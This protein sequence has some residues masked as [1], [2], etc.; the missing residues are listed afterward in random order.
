MA[1]LKLKTCPFCGVPVNLTDN[2][3][4]FGWHDTKCFF[5][6]L[7]ETNVLDMTEEEADKAY[8]DAW[9]RRAD[10]GRHFD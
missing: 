7:D 1:D 4:I 2:G 3:E 9:N 5:S 6:F 8:I 10:N